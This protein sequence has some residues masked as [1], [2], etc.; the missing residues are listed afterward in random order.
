RSGEQMLIHALIF[1]S[2]AGLNPNMRICHAERSE[3]SRQFE[4]VLKKYEQLRGFFARQ[5][6]AGSE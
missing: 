2:S 4:A 3:A 5:K 6:M 1:Q